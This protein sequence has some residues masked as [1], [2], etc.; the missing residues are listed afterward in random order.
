MSWRLLKL[1]LRGDVP[2]LSKSG[3]VP[4]A[5]KN[6]SEGSCAVLRTPE[7]QK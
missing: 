3:H 5:R 6:V 7:V 4:Q 2:A 1:E